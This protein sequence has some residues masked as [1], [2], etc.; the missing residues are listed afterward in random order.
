MERVDRR[1]QMQPSILVA[2]AGKDHLE[3]TLLEKRGPSLKKILQ[4][5]KKRVCS[6]IP[7]ETRIAENQK[8]NIH[9]SSNSPALNP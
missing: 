5:V 1:R 9:V 2:E 8:I 4:L 3:D 7:G 6:E